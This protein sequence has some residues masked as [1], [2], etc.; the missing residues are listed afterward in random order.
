MVYSD[1]DTEEVNDL[2][3]PKLKR[4][5]NDDKFEFTLPSIPFSVPPPKPLPL[6]PSPPRPLPPSLPT[7]PPALHIPPPKASSPIAAFFDDLSVAASEHRD[8]L[9]KVNTLYLD[10]LKDIV[11]E[12][13]HGHDIDLQGMQDALHIMNIIQGVRRGQRYA[14]VES[15]TTRWWKNIMIGV[16]SVVVYVYL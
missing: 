16:A 10:E 5:K 3:P 2:S 13:G 15:K 8:I 12:I 4:C 1:S 7:K 9:A 11:D 14:P 6:S